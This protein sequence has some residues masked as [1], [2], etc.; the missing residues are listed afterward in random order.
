MFDVP[1][2]DIVAVHVDEDAVL[3]KKQVKYVR[4]QERE[5]AETSSNSREEAASLPRTG[6]FKGD[7]VAAWPP[8][9]LYLYM[10]QSQLFIPAIIIISPELF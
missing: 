2:S 3:G 5:A 1:H 4:S 9:C 10:V 8:E 7:S 6:C